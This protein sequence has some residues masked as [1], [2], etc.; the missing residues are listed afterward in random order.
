M[1]NDEELAALKARVAELERKPPPPPSEADIARYRDEMHAM[2]ERN[3]SH[4]PSWMREAC[5]G[6][7]RDEDARDLVRASHRPN[8]PS[9]AGAIP[10]SQMVTC[11]R[12]GG[13]PARVPGGGT[14][15]LDPVPISPPPGIALVDALCI[16]DDM[17][18][19]AERKRKEG[20]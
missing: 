18:Q 1:T 9:S 10:S 19:R 11:V 15:W 20:G 5:A 4:I 12:P 13:G 17:R 3:A 7:V 16:A 6:G 2:R 14:G 8:G